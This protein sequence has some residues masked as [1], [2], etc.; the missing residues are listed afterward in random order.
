MKNFLT[1]IFAMV[2]IVATVAFCMWFF[3]TWG[4]R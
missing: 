2:G 3:M 4:G 1:D